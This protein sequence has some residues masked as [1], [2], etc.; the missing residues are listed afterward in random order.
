VDVGN[1]NASVQLSTTAFDRGINRVC[2]GFSSAGMGAM[3]LNQ[4]LDLLSRGFRMASQA[5]EATI[6]TFIK[7]ADTSEKY[8]LTLDTLLGSQAEGA[9]MFKEMSKFAQNVPFEYEKIMDSA[10]ALGGVMKGGVDEVNQWMPMISDLAAVS[11]L[12][13]EQTTGQIVRMYSA[14]AAS[15]DLFREKGITAMLGFLPGVK[16]S[17]EETR[18]LLMKAF[19][20]PQSKFAGASALL[21]KTWSGM[22][23]MLADR[24]FIFR[25]KV[26]ESG[27]FEGIKD[28]LQ[29]ILDLFAVWAEDGTLDKWAAKTAENFKV[30]INMMI[31]TIGFFMNAWYSLRSAGAA[32]MEGLFKGMSWLVK[33]LVKLEK[34]FYDLINGLIRGINKVRKFFGTELI[35]E[36]QSSTDFGY[37]DNLAA[38]FKG[39]ENIWKEVK[40]EA[41]DNIGVIEGAVDKL[42]VKL[43]EGAKGKGKQLPKIVK[44]AEGDNQLSQEIEKATEKIQSSLNDAMFDAQI[45]K[46]SDLEKQV[47]SAKRETA[48]LREEYWHLFEANP[49]L[50]DMIVQLGDLNIKNIE[51]ADAWEKHQESIAAT[52]DKIK[53]ALDRMEGPLTDFF[54]TFAESGKLAFKELGAALIKELQMYAAQ[55]TAQLLMTAAFE[56]IMGF[57]YG[58]KHFANAIAALEGAAIMG[59]F[60]AGSG[61]AGMAESGITNIPENGTWLLHKNERVVDADTNADLKKF[62]AQGGG[63]GVTIGTIEINGGDEEG[64]RKALPALKKT[65]LETVNGDISGNGQTL[66]TIKAYAR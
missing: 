46:L 61:L 10:T 11:R 6:G 3:K 52:G 32:V 36:V 47:I 20:D 48:Q 65:I 19:E 23:S 55:K 26:M 57:I 54:M 2:K 7:A 25:N 31:R 5:G 63:G 49:A 9:R 56:G 59:S 51:A 53:E 15:A 64:V 38:K 34:G 16:Y 62:L 33:G 42:Y 30:A 45:M 40:N 37:L 58:G 60:V 18:K 8:K 4:T 12:S 39:D 22:L 35:S 28:R 43:R 50:D 1:L 41:L 29:M 21:A 44:P 13:I 17:A 24:W 66:K 14:G 27:L